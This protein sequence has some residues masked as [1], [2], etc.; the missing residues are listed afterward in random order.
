MLKDWLFAYKMPDVGYG[1]KFSNSV[2]DKLRSLDAKG[3]DFRI[4][5][6]GEM[7][8]VPKTDD[9]HIMNIRI[10]SGIRKGYIKTLM[11][12]KHLHCLLANAR[13]F[14]SVELLEDVYGYR[15]PLIWSE[16]IGSFILRI[17]DKT[18]E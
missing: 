2:T 16:D 13:F 7:L 10:Q 3:L 6:E 8:I 18:E 14:P 15:F 1:V 17:Q 4:V 9:E 11:N 5:T 12:S